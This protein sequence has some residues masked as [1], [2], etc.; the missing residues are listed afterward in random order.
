MAEKPEMPDE[1]GCPLWMVSFG[2]TISLL[3]CFFVM[4]VSFASFEEDALMETLGALQGG[5]RAIPMPDATGMSQSEAATAADESDSAHLPKT[6]D[7]LGYS[8][9]VSDYEASANRLISTHTQDYFV[10]LLR[11]DLTL[12]I[13]KNGLFN[14]GT[15]EL[16]PGNANIWRAVV[17]LMRAVRGEARIE[18]TLW[19]HA[20]VQSKLFSTPWGLGLEQAMAIRGLLIGEYGMDSSQISTAVRVVN[21]AHLEDVTNGMIEIV[22]VGVSAAE[23]QYLV[24]RVV[25]GT[26]RESDEKVGSPDGG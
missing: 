25:S 19:D 22:Y 4:L 23:S 8:V 13:R 6:Y 2:D 16:N 1:V 10:R 24:E 18:V 3:V 9:E 20:R 26:W 15:A 7:D 12:V 14:Q 11:N 17:T 5:L 21:E